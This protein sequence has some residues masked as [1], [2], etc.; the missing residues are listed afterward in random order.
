MA[1]PVDIT[2]F[3]SDKFITPGI[4]DTQYT[5]AREYGFDY[6]KVKECQELSLTGCTTT[7]CFISC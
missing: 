3:T 2:I 1:N 5:H 6:A 4:L 7:G